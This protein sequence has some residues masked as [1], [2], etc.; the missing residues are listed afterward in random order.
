MDREALHGGGDSPEKVQA[1]F[2]TLAM[3]FGFVE[4]PRVAADDTLYFSDL[5]AGGY[6]RKRPGEAASAILDG[7]KWI[8]GSILNEDGTILVSGEGGIVRIHPQTGEVTTILDKLGGVAVDAVNDMEADDEGGVYGGTVDFSAILGRGEMGRPGTLFRIDPSGTVEVL[9][10][11]VAVSNGIGFSPDRS[12]FYHS[13][14]TVG[15]WAYDYARG[16]RPRNPVLFAKLEDSD[17][18]V[19]DAEG[20]VWVARWNAAEILRF[21]PDGVLDRRLGVPAA[22][23]TSLDFGGSDPHLLYVA[24]GGRDGDGNPAGGVVRIRID[25]PGQPSLPGRI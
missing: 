12:V 2:E 9:R 19:V 21:R 14:S 18:L 16:G 20:G 17:G 1:P 24:T 6:Y 7:R 23:I 5:L 11:G 10:E 3:G 4:A 22:N 15:I 13:D 25:V 8:G